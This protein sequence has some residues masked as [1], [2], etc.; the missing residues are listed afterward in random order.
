LIE[1]KKD[2][3]FSGCLTTHRGTKQWLL[4][5]RIPELRAHTDLIERLVGK[6]RARFRLEARLSLRCSAPQINP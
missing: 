5:R 3:G 6:E 2:V 1:V 4:R